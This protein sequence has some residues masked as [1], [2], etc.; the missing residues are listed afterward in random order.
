ME[1]VIDEV[2]SGIYRIS[3]YIAEADFSFNQ[4]LVDAEQPLL[5]HCGMRGLFPLVSAAVA[6]V[7]PVSHVRWLSFGHWE[8]A[9][10]GFIIG[11]SLG[12]R[13]LPLR[14]ETGSAVP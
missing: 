12:Q 13:D 10:S 5:F 14:R 2:T 11:T 7:M 3:T 9:E 1:T 4:Y 8:A 6:K